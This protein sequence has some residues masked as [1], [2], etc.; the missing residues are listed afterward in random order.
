VG[1]SIC[2]PLTKERVKHAVGPRIY[3]D[4]AYRFTNRWKGNHYMGIKITL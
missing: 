2:A 3:F 4:Y 1:A